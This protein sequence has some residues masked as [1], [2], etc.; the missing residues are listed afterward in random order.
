MSKVPIVQKLACALIFVIWTQRWDKEYWG[1]ELNN[2]VGS[3]IYPISLSGMDSLLCDYEAAP[4]DHGSN[5]SPT[6]LVN[7]KEPHSERKMP[8][9]QGSWIAQAENYLCTFTSTTE[10]GIPY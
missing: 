2:T 5:I 1:P 3:H 8:H 4:G 10:S 6:V 7:F 9:T